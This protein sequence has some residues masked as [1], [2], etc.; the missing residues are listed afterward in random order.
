MSKL[1][2]EKQRKERNPYVCDPKNMTLQVFPSYCIF[3]EKLI[4]LRDGMLCYFCLLFT[5]RLAL[6]VR[7]YW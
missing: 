5:L 3:P 4:S 1:K 2:G 7:V 6:L